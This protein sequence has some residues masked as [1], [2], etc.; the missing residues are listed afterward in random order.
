MQYALVIKFKLDFNQHILLYQ[1]ENNNP[2]RYRN[3]SIKLEIVERIAL[4][5]VKRVGKYDVWVHRPV[6]RYV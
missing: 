1:K 2:L 5:Y 3:I 6:K 4:S